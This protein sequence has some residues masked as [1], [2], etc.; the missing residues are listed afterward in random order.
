VE[1]QIA[2]PE[3]AGSN[4]AP[5]TQKAAQARGFLVR[6]AQ[7]RVGG[8][9]QL[10]P[11]WDEADLRRRVVHGAR[12]RSFEPPLKV[13]RAFE[14]RAA[15]DRLGPAGRV[16][17]HGKEGVD[18]SSPSEGFTKVP[19]KRDFFIQ[20]DLLQAQRAM[21]MERGMEPSV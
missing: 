15:T 12:R 14:D 1:P 16:P 18:G 3:V 6:S 19:Q 11:C 4:P 2:Y 5:T 13:G 9:A 7:I 17:P 8:F 10:S 21:G 20:I